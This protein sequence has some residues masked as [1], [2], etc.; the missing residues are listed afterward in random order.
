[1]Y[2]SIFYRDKLDND[3]YYGSD[4]DL[5]R[6]IPKENILFTNHERLVKLMPSPITNYVVSVMT[7]HFVGNGN[8][9]VIEFHQNRVGLTPK[10]LMNLADEMIHIRHNAK[11]RFLKRIEKN[12]DSLYKIVK[13]N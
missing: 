5:T 4:F 13:G 6:G 8:F 1:M 3:T 10:R 7:K 12:M 2:V 11:P 9:L